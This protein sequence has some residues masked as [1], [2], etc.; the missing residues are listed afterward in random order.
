MII[1]YNLKHI[2]L[3]YKISMGIVWEENLYILF[4]YHLWRFKLAFKQS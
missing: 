4:K 2:I 3:K 1:D